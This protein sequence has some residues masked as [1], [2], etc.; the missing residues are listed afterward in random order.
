MSVR[1]SQ[2]GEIECW[3]RNTGEGITPDRL[4]Q[5]FV[6]GEVDPKKKGSSGL[7]L[8]IVKKAVEAHGG[9]LTVESK[10]GEG[11]TF[12]F[13]LPVNIGSPGEHV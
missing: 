4:D 8:S 5:I 12:R 6:K 11:S 13:T 2:K 9:K 3:V 7:G 1:T 10:P